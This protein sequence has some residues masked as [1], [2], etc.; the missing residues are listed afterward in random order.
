MDD[1][2]GG[3]CPDRLQLISRQRTDEAAE[4]GSLRD[5]ASPWPILLLI[6]QPARHAEDIGSATLIG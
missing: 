1:R 2:G 6:N 3:A 5:K 4:A